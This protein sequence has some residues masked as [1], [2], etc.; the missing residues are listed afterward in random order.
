MAITNRIKSV[1]TTPE[2]PEEAEY[3]TVIEPATSTVVNGETPKSTPPI[4][5]AARVTPPMIR[6]LNRMP[7]YKARN[8]RR[9]AA[10]LPE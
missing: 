10:G 5:V 9:N 2:S 8:P 1:A 7:R 3:S 6:T 4:F